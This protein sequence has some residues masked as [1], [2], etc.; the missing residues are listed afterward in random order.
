MEKLSIRDGLMD[1]AKQRI[2]LV[3]PGRQ[4]SFDV[5]LYC[6]QANH[7]RA[8]LHIPQSR[9]FEYEHYALMDFGVADMETV[10]MVCTLLGI[11]YDE[12]IW[13]AEELY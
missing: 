10:L 11:E 7:L 1:L 5:S 8:M 3:T 13:E 9:D 2:E 4:I 6:D 12:K